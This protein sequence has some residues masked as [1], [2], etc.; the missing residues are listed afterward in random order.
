MAVQTTA[1]E[2]ATRPQPQTTV[3]PSS[4][5]LAAS[6]RANRPQYYLTG[7]S[8]GAQFNQPLPGAPGYLRYFDLTVQATGGANATTTTVAGNTAASAA[9]DFGSATGPVIT[10]AT[11]EPALPVRDI[12]GGSVDGIVQFV[13]VQ[14]AHGTT[15]FSG[16]GWDMFHALPFVSGAVGILAGADTNVFASY[17]STGVASAG[18]T[19]T[20]NTGNFRARMRIPFEIV[21]GYGCLGVGDTNLQPRVNLQLQSSGTLYTTAPSTLATLQVTLD[22]AYY[23]VPQ[24]GLAPPG[25]GTTMQAVEVTASPTVGS[26]ASNRIA[27]GRLG[28]RM[29][30]LLLIARNTNGQR[31]GNI[32]PAFGSN[33]RIRLILD[34]V[35]VLDESIEERYDKMSLSTGGLLGSIN[36]PA[37]STTATGRTFPAGVLFYTFKDYEAQAN[38]GLLDNGLGWVR[39]QPG[40]LLEL[41]CTPWGTFSNGPATITAVPIVVVPGREGVS[42]S[43]G[44]QAAG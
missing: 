28:G 3:N 36:G 18:G 26:G 39:T 5:F 9:G 40:T 27:I 30:G 31:D 10:T 13:T 14:D 42:Q 2:T 15:V 34:G 25:L 20:T 17:F 33:N 38:L 4:D 12:I 37:Y 1:G 16:P 7:Q 21:P 22:A 29:L 6:K 44:I 23:S 41:E 35:T 11:T 19:A 24:S 32:W 8:Y 43:G